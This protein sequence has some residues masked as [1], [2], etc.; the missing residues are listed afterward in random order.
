MTFSGVGTALMAAFLG[1]AAVAQ[2][3]GLSTKV[4]KGSLYVR[5]E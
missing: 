3:S 5:F 2:V 4:C 1:L